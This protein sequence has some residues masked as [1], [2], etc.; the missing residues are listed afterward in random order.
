L[1]WRATSSAPCWT[2]R[3]TDYLLLLFRGWLMVTLVSCN[4]IQIARKQTARAVFVG[5]CISLVWWFNA[6]AAAVSGAAMGTYTGIKIAG[7]G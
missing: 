6:H 3:L 5:F 4:T 7:K 1:G 2:G